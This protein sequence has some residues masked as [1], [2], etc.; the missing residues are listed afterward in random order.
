MTVLELMQKYSYEETAPY[1]K[2]LFD[3][4]SGEEHSLL[5]LKQWGILYNHWAGSVEGIPCPYHI[6]VVSR[7]EYCS[8]MIDMNCSVYDSNNHPQW[9]LAEHRVSGEILGMKVCVDKDVTI[10]NE[11]LVA[12]LFWE[13]TYRETEDKVKILM[14][15][16]L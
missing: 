16:K 4:N 5:S 15:H 12:G 1:L 8:P 14:T 9:P 7:W 13:M 3:V 11:E 10:N 2:H 6:R